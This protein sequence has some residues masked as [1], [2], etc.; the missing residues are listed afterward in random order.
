MQTRII[1][2]R[3]GETRANRQQK[4]IGTTESKLTFYGRYQGKCLKKRMAGAKIDK[5]FVSPSKRAVDFCKI[6]FGGKGQKLLVGLQEMN[7]GIFEGLTYSKALKKYPEICAKWFKNPKR[8][9]VPEAESFNSFKRRVLSTIKKIIRGNRGKTIAIVTH[10]G[11][12]MLVLG[13]ILKLKKPFEIMP[14]PAS[15]T[16]IEFKKLSPKILALN[17]T[18]HYKWSPAGRRAAPLIEVRD[19]AGRNPAPKA[20]R[21]K[22]PFSYGYACGILVRG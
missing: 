5:I 20:S 19:S 13:S 7:F 2:I 9:N 10:G 1:L 4:Y 17:D 12:I 16:I 6:V 14:K 11:P 22:I 15:I 18:S 8:F 3:H 21:P